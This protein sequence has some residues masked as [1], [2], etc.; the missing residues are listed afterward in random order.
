[1]AQS[2]GLLLK[3]SIRSA[4]ANARQ[5]ETVVVEGWSKEVVD[6]V[7]GCAKFKPLYGMVL[8]PTAGSDVDL[9]ERNRFLHCVMI[10]SL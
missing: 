2:C 6:F 5:T 9:S 4:L 10:V 3:V 8:I 1:M 7:A